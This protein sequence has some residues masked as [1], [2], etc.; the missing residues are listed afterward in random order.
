MQLTHGQKVGQHKIIEYIGKSV[1]GDAYSVVFGSTNRKYA[2][3]IIS[4]DSGVTVDALNEYIKSLRKVQSPCIIKCFAA[5][6]SDGYRWIRT[7]RPTGLKQNNLFTNLVLKD[8][9]DKNNKLVFDLDTLIEESK[10]TGGLAGD[11]CSLILY[12]V[13]ETVSNLHAYDMYVGSSFSNPVLDKQ[14]KPVGVVVRIPVVMWPAVEDKTDAFKADVVEAGCL[15]EKV[16]KAVNP[17]ERKWIQAR[18]SLLK[19]AEKAKNLDGYDAACQLYLDFVDILSKKGIKY[20]ERCTVEDFILKPVVSV[21]S[22]AEEENVDVDRDTHHLSNNAKKI[23]SRK[24]KH[25]SAFSKQRRHSSYQKY[26]TSNQQ[27]LRNIKFVLIILLLFGLCG[28]FAYLLYRPEIHGEVVSKEEYSAISI[29]GESTQEYMD[30]DLPKYVEDYSVEQLEGTYSQNPLAAARYATMLWFGTDGVEQNKDTAIAIVEKNKVEYDEQYKFDSEIEFWRAYLM[31]LGIG[32]EQQVDEAEKTLD[33]L[34]NEGISK[35]GLLLG[36]FYAQKTTGDSKENDVK[37]MNYWRLATKAVH[38]YK[39]ETIIAMNRIIYFI[40]QERGIPTNEK[41]YPFL[42]NDLKRY[43]NAHGVKHILSQW[44]LAELNY[45]GSKYV[46]GENSKVEAYNFYKRLADNREYVHEVVRAEAY[47]YLG[48]M[49]LNGDL[50]K[51]IPAAYNNYVKAANLGNAFAMQKLIN[52]YQEENL[53][54]ILTEEEQKAAKDIQYWKD[55]YAKTDRVKILGVTEPSYT[56]FTDEQ[57]KLYKQPKPMPI[58]LSIYCVDNLENER[59]TEIKK[60]FTT[61]IYTIKKRKIKK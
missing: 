18:E 24:H 3:H 13:L 20:Y 28:G 45:N 34:A 35:A 22:S 17:D 56:I 57:K 9:E 58:T 60:D 32:Y 39:L 31:L 41:E 42:I 27:V 16:V 5:G 21:N 44:M 1:F 59:T 48:D 6:E 49:C 54:E 25:K 10:S 43:A 38:G 14:L 36:D 29:I 19:L 47:V 50:N 2:L 40:S 61:K 33:K 55:L 52:L 8:E 11:D 23:S 51:S 26:D 46:S 4:E 53:N 15:I 37:A 12:D 30:N 7:E